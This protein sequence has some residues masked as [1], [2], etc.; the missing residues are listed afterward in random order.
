MTLFHNNSNLMH[1]T[2]HECS[3]QKP[4]NPNLIP[5]HSELKNTSNIIHPTSFTSSTH[6][7]LLFSIIS[8]ST[9]LNPHS[10]SKFSTSESQVKIYNT[11]KCVPHLNLITLPPPTYSTP[12]T[13]S[14]LNYTKNISHALHTYP[15]TCSL[16]YFFGVVCKWCPWKF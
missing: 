8:T 10:N 7:T 2:E 1:W 11:R 12:S 13:T 14:L 16:S 15:I 6:Y 3:N 4:K 9:H 5:T